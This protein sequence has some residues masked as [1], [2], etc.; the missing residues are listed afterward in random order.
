MS[1][2]APPKPPLIDDRPDVELEALIK[3]A[4]QRARRRRQRNAAAGL[5]VVLLGLAV[6][7][8][9][10]RGGGATSVLS[11]AFPAQGPR[12]A[13]ATSVT[14]RLL[15]TPTSFRQVDLPPKGVESRG[16]MMYVKAVLRNWSRQFHRPP[17]AVVGSDSWIYTALRSR[18]WSL[19]KAVVKLPGGTL[20]LYGRV[21]VS[22]YVRY[23]PVVGGTGRFANARGTCRVQER[24]SLPSL[25]DYRL[26]IPT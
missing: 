3:E 26:R 20:R 15:S 16:D 23:V 12:Q 6:Y 2:T 17:N 10:A 8:G 21:H 11:A 25:N 18:G 4:R 22:S 14:F 19:V 7:A 13:S 9:F 1:V 24:A 5:V